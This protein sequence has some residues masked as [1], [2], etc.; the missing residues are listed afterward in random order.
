M[1]WFVLPTQP[2]HEAVNIRDHAWPFL[3]GTIA[4]IVDCPG[5]I[6]V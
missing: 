6:R 3:C 2:E 4:E 5:Q 1:E